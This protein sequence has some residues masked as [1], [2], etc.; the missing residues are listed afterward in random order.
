MLYTLTMA[1]TLNISLSEGQKDWLNSRREAAG[2]SSASD[3]VRDLIRKQQEVEQADLRRLFSALDNDGSDEPEPV[4]AVLKI[5]Q[6]VKR[7]RRG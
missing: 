6:E 5:V 4:E 2:F 1:S 7:E 3:V